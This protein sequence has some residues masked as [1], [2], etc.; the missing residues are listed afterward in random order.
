MNL[1]GIIFN[2]Q[3]KIYCPH[4]LQQWDILLFFFFLDILIFNHLIICCIW[5]CWVF[6]AVQASL[7][8][9]RAGATVCCNV[10]A[11]H[12]SGFS[13]CGAW[14]SAVAARGLS[15]CGSLTPEHRLNS[16]RAQ[17]QLLQAYGIFPDQGSNPCLP[18]WQANSLLLSPQESPRIFLFL[19]SKGKSYLSPSI[20]YVQPKHSST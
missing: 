18:N 14:A 1:K 20:N 17:A 4:P 12:C 19:L 2:Y 16:C 6:V 13:C 5:L 10:Q 7:Q 3:W 9:W 11:S 15:S 8:L